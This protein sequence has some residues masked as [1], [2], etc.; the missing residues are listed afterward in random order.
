MLYGIVPLMYVQAIP[1]S[2][3]W[4][5]LNNSLGKVPPKSLSLMLST[6]FRNLEV[7]SFEGDEFAY[8]ICLL[9]KSWRFFTSDVITPENEFQFKINFSR[10]VSDVISGNSLPT[11]PKFFL[12]LESTERSTI[13]PSL[14]IQSRSLRS[15]RARLRYVSG[16]WN[17]FLGM[18]PSKPLLSRSKCLSFVSDPI[19]VGIVP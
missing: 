18:V 10:L 14:V 1:I 4:G 8:S 17:K 19:S 16:K 15:W 11:S 5:N 7:M 3:R 6:S 13:S 12:P 2:R 9:P